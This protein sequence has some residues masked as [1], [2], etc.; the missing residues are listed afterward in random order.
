MQFLFKKYLEYE[1]SFGDEERI[2]YVKRKA[3][4]YVESTNAWYTNLSKSQPA[5]VFEKLKFWQEAVTG[6]GNARALYTYTYW[7]SWPVMVKFLQCQ[8]KHVVIYFVPQFI[9]ICNVF[10]FFSFFFVICPILLTASVIIRLDYLTVLCI[11]FSYRACK[12]YY[13]LILFLS[14]QNNTKML[15]LFFW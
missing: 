13:S 12:D 4:E 11:I 8:D 15:W 9:N 10:D 14:R 6:E 1:K 5:L 3:M 2:E 7:R